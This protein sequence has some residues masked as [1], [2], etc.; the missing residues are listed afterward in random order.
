MLAIGLIGVMGLQRLRPGVRV[1]FASRHLNA[2]AA[3]GA[4]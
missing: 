1:R 2:P 4:W 3:A